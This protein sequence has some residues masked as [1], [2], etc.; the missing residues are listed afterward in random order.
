M[1][2]K[3]KDKNTTKKERRNHNHIWRTLHNHTNHT[4]PLEITL[5]RLI[6]TMWY[7]LQPTTF[8]VSRSSSKF[9]PSSLGLFQMWNKTRN[10]QKKEE[11]DTQHTTYKGQPPLPPTKV[12]KQ[13]Y[14]FSERL[15]NSTSQNLKS[16]N[17]TKGYPARAHLR[18]LFPFWR[19]ETNPSSWW[20]SLQQQQIPCGFQISN[21]CIP[22][23]GYQRTL[24]P[25]NARSMPSWRLP[26]NIVNS[27][28]ISLDTEC[29]SS[30]PIHH[31]KMFRKCSLQQ[32][33]RSTSDRGLTARTYSP[34]T[35]LSYTGLDYCGPIATKTVK[36]YIAI[37]ICFSTKAVHL[38]SVNS[39]S[40]EAYNLP[41]YR[42]TFF[43]RRG[44]PIAI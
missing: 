36:V 28:T 17:K 38:E 4:G 22:A 15:K 30:Y 2:R 3:N 24:I 31:S 35:P 33:S 26:T 43:A 34:S 7:S 19:R 27:K 5:I 32:P 41:F 44:L 40:T 13:D 18:P 6:P 21:Y 16:S 10:R 37:F 9:S 1:K 11:H 12:K 20:T 14:E 23:V 8:R 42:R 29:D 39:I 25:R